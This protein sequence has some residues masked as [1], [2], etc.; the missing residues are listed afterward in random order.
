MAP[1][2]DF[3][4]LSAS[5]YRRFSA[6]YRCRLPSYC[7]TASCA[8]SQAGLQ[9]RFVPALASGSALNDS[10]QFRHSKA[11]NSDMT[12]VV[13]ARSTK[14]LDDTIAPGN[15]LRLHPIG[16]Q[17]CFGRDRPGGRVLVGFTVVLDAFAVRLLYRASRAGVQ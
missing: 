7:S 15:E 4:K 5:P 13:R 6:S 2:A 1:H 12:P 9:R 10:P 8:V 16:V 3:E 17:V 14:T 11:S